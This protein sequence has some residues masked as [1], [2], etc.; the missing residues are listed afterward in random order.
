[1]PARERRPCY[2]FIQLPAR[3]T[4]QMP[5][6]SGLTDP[7]QSATVPFY[8]ACW[9]Q[10]V[11]QISAALRDRG[12]HPTQA[13]V[14]LPY[15]Q[16]IEEARN[17][18][19][20]QLEQPDGAVFLPRFE[21]TQSWANNPGGV[22][23]LFTPTGNDL[24]LDVAVDRLTADSLLQQA[25]LGPQQSVL[26]GRLVEAAWSLAGVAAAVRPAE[27]PAWGERLG[28]L[29]QANL[30]SPVL[31]FENAMGRIALAWAAASAYPTDRLFDA[32]PDF[33]VIVQGFRQEPLVPALLAHFGSRAMA[34]TLCAAAAGT[35][36][37]A[38]GISM[39]A[40][41]DAE[42]EAVQAAACVLAHLAGGR[43]TV[44]LI[45]QDRL[46][47]RRVGAMLQAHGVATRDE[48]GWKLSTTRAAAT[49]LGLLRAMTHDA[50]ADAVLDWLKN[51]PA[52]VAGDVDRVEAE[53]RKAGLRAWRDLPDF[54]AESA[55]PERDPF[56]VTRQ[57]APRVDALRA[58]LAR[59]RPLAL[60]LRD[61]RLALVAAGQWDSLAA[62][63]AG[64]AVLAVLRLHDGL[65]LE[66]ETAPSVNL[67]A[68]TR[69]A[70]EALE[71]GNFVPPR[72]QSTARGEV[73]VM[74]LPQLL[75]R[76]VQAVVLPGCD[77]IR[78]SVSPEPTGL[79]TLRQRE[80]LGLA[81]RATLAAAA[82]AAW[83][84]ALQLAHVDVLWR[85]SQA[86]EHLVPSGFVQE[87]L[88]DCP[89]ALAPDV[90][91]LREVTVYPT[92]R[93]RP[94]GAS[95]PVTRLSASA[96][97]DLRRCPYRFF[98]L[99]Q[100]KLQ[101][102]EELESELGK[103]DFGNWLHNV[104]KRFH[105][106]LK[107]APAQ[108]IRARTAII[109]IAADEATRELAMHSSEFLPFA[110]IWPRVRAGYLDWLAAHEA[111]GAVYEAGEVWRE[112]PY[113]NLTLVGK[114][115]RLDQLDGALLV[116]DYKTEPRSTTTERIKSGPEDTQLAFY[117]AL[118]E[119]DTLQ[120]AY[121][122][123]GEKEPTKTYAQ[124]EIV[125]LR[126]DLIDS[127]LTD[128]ARIARGAA[129]PALGEGKACDHCAARGLC[130]KDF[131][132]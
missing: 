121:V 122:N 108:E 91:A 118:M 93:P 120:A 124:P 14:L 32:E 7:L 131:W 132:T 68:F 69:W 58:P 11:Q 41:A 4:C 34:V 39:H 31:A 43:N 17:A 85:T 90:R 33:V 26:A 104:L 29:L 60:R 128:M 113:G 56:E 101:E 103:R 98:A 78:M 44:A 72:P 35:P 38:A 89:A 25:G 22:P 67:T 12:L 96:Y 92:P 105:E 57:L 94:S 66:F 97:E 6:I 76:S 86:G 48:T 24:R 116:I 100:L 79:W 42:D 123:L 119:A 19:G 30:D 114:L 49:V 75:G 61:L 109:N 125:Q 50:S 59:T 23:G 107:D 110:A 99:R 2:T 3:T 54:A 88:L 83:T 45:S 47:T 71:G 51:A 112:M 16:L 28:Q 5:T 64:Q 65:E 127:I 70:D 52:F 87:R 27:R 77:E 8:T 130:R 62:D 37:S 106:M 117:A 10:L 111:G 53:L 84:Y 129:L 95:L 20:L 82:R 55:P 73:I 18:W 80:L 115:D 13:V 21:T 40:A 46:L 126:D 102:P 74:P 15:F 63:D 81:S 1:M 9:T 36:P